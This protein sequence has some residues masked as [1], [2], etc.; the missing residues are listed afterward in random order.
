M[1]DTTFDVNV[2]EK[3]ILFDYIRHLYI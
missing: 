1:E 3:K 2:R